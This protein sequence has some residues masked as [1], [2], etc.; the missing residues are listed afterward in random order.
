MIN[1]FIIF[2]PVFPS[3]LFRL[4][5]G[6]LAVAILPS[7]GFAYDAAGSAS[8]SS[9]SFDYATA[10]RF[11]PAN[12][13]GSM[14]NM[15]VDP[16]WI[17]GTHSFWYLKTGRNGQEFML[18]D[19]QNSTKKPAFNH[20]LLALSLSQATGEAVDPAHLPFDEI[21]I[22]PGSNEIEFWAFSRT[23]QFNLKSGQIVD[24]PA[25][26]EV[27][28]GEAL[29]PDGRFAAFVRDH[30]LWIRDA[31][32]GEKYPLTSDGTEDYA[33]AERSDTVSHPVSLVRLN[34]TATP[35]LVWSPDSRRIA[36]FRMDQRNVTE[37]HLLQYAPDNGS[38]PKLWTY[39]FA[40]PADEA[41]PMYEPIVIDVQKREVIAVSYQAQPEVSLMDT[42]DDV[43]Q[44][45]S[46]DG[47]ALYSLYALRGEK[48]LL[49]LKTD[50]ANGQT[51]EILG[52]KGRTYVEA[53]L[54]YASLPNVRVLR[55]GDL[56]WFSEKNGYGNLYLYGRDGR[57]K[58]IITSGDWVV[59]ELLFVD[60]NNCQI[61]FTAGGRE[62]GRDPYYRH[63]YRCNLSGGD[64]QLLTIEDAD[65]DIQ[66]NPEGTAFVDTYSRVDKPP[67]SVIRD[68][69]GSVTLDLEIGDIKNITDMGWTSP[70]RI[71]VKALDGRTDLYGLIIKPT[72]YSASQKYPVVET[73]YPGPWTTVTTKS[74]PCDL[75]FTSKVFWRAQAVAELGFIV[76]TL[77]GPGTPYRSKQFHDASYGHLG[78]AGYLPEH[79]NALKQL[80]QE[81]PYMDL[82]RV[83][84][85]GH[86]AGGFMTAQALLTYPQFYRVGVASGGD[87]DSRFYG[88][89]WGEKYEGL[90]LSDYGEQITSRKAGD[91]TGKL[92]LIT[93]DVDDNVNP[94]MTM[95]LVN[96]FIDADL[97][98]DL[99]VMTNRNHDLSYE[100]YYLHRLFRYL[101]ENLKEA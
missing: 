45:W 39:R 9:Q 5:A 55:N 54:D 94:C 97:P 98:F 25:E 61:Y 82:S 69:N 34:E 20:S 93:G 51:E 30:N 32:N 65:H 28:P 35:Y 33:Y 100:T 80:A 73:V 63:L 76:V 10:Q 37:M 22:H 44:W 58:S 89:Y 86:S 6:L 68:R 31:E 4:I 78:D 19:L 70:E 77:D 79:I 41:I 21:T 53:N 75:S 42:D 40:L 64:L 7:S 16:H 60:E 81:R 46:D 84:M 26:H 29:S 12:A 47:Q 67:V 27:M 91:L 1:R 95:Q 50:P 18:V 23:M 90:N 2:G 62:P 36:T 66:V 15:S 92:L 52:E 72:S 17:A 85:F 57:Q 101:E 43:L 96:A 3:G 88:A 38:R 99:L 8:L 87:Y 49:L 71:Q 59:R 83:G 14:F 56:V 11:V 74:F 13:I 48:A 24:A